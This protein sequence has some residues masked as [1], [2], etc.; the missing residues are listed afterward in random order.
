MT[1]E[2]KYGNITRQSFSHIKEVLEMPYL[3]E[4]QVDSYKQFV[5][6]TDAPVG[7]NTYN[8]IHLLSLNRNGYI[9]NLRS[10]HI[11]FYLNVISRELIKVMNIRI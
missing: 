3:L 11:I 7:I 1:H 4:A 10:R 9:F 6:V 2:V 5:F 8:N